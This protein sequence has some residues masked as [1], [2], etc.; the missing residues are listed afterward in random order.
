MKKR[1]WKAT[2]KH[3]RG[4]PF[5]AWLFAAL[6]VL[7]CEGLLRLWSG[8]DVSFLRIC[9]VGLLAVT[10]GAGLGLLASLFPGKW[11][12]GAAVLLSALTVLVYLLE[13]FLLDA[14]HNFMPFRTV[15]AGAG[16]VAKDY[17]GLVMELL[18]HDLW[19][20]CLMAAPV[21]VYGLW[22][23]NYVVDWGLRA[24]LAETTVG[25]FLLA[26]CAI[27]ALTG[28]AAL[29]GRAFEFDT[30][31]RTFGLGT[32]LT[33]DLARGAGDREPEFVEA[34]EPTETLPAETEETVPETQPIEYGY[35]EMDIDFAGFAKTV[36]DY[37][38]ASVYE[39][40]DSLT[41]SRQNAYTGLFAGKNLIF[42]TAEAFSAEVID[43]SLTPT[44]YRMANEGIR[45]QEYYQPAWGASTTTGEYSNLMGIMPTAG[46]GSMYDVLEQDYFLTMGRQLQKL[47]YTSIA[48]H[49][50][51]FDFYDRFL[52]HPQ[53]GYDQFIAWGT[54]ME[55]QIT[56]TWPQSDKEMI[57]FSVPQY[58]GR[59]PFS[60]YYMT[61]SAH[62][63]Y[64]LN[65]NA[66]S[67]RNWDLVQH[68]ECSDTLKCYFAA[69]LELEFAMESLLRQL[70][71]A[72]I[73][74][75]TV[76]VL[77]TDH[78]PY[79]LERSATWQNNG[80]C[81]AELYG[82]EE[83][84]QFIR[85]HNA[86]IIWSGCIEDKDIVVEEPVYSL[87]ILPTLSNLF[88][89]EYDS[90]LLVGRDV[91]SNWEPLVLWPNFSW[92]TDKGTYDFPKA[93]FTP[94][95][96]VSVEE[97]YVER[98]NSIVSNKI[99]YSRS[100]NNVNLFAWLAYQMSVG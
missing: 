38:V 24:I 83:Y 99:T 73:A 89:L 22:G 25:A 81:L 52:T 48:Y 33:L 8:A 47:G 20:I 60:I 85:D 37:S 57:D 82:V 13:F 39:Y 61:V 87:D 88:G 30:A 41:P 3:L 69:N 55:N 42:I 76:I 93:T 35:N 19:R 40:V 58:I 91:F 29:L 77:A 63:V 66:M 32:A 59:Q 67:R 18:L 1:L 12:K 11:G 9:V 49:P 64:S 78:Y 53:L 75:D 71:E 54:G 98:I 79:G 28:D 4:F 95:E 97:G 92:V 16:G 72:G 26:M 50:H 51:L 34:P 84:D 23:R 31:V 17:F 100:V 36:G 27:H 45:F 44:L 68:L 80:D 14:Y 74:D 56:N 5:P 86:L 96:G 43:R 15:L 21:V 70:E 65:Y 6:M 10:F 62:S 2:E 46:G 90:R 94:R 7:Y